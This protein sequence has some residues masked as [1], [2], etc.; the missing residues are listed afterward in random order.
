[1]HALK[2]LEFDAIRERL[3]ER[4]ETAI[5]AARALELTP[6]FDEAKVWGHLT[7]TGEA[8]DAQGR[9]SVPSLGAVRDLRGPIHRAGKGG[10]LGGQ[11]LFQIGDAMTAMRVMKAFLTP[12]AEEYSQLGLLGKSLPEERRV[13]DALMTSLEPDGNVRDEASAAL[14]SLRKR[15]VAAFGR[16]VE[17]IQSY[18]TGRHRELLSDPIYTL[19][20]GRYVIPV[21]AEN[22]GKI[23]GIVHDTSASGQT[24]YLEPEDVLQLG[25]ALREIEAAEREE[26]VRI[27][28]D[29]SGR[30]GSAAGALIP[31][32]ELAGALDLL[33]AKGRLGADCRGTM[34]QRTEG[35]AWIKVEGGRHPLLDPERAIPLDI[36]V[37][38]DSS[39][40][41]T[42]PNT[43]GKTVAIKTVGLFVAMAQSGLMLPARDV[44]LGTF[45]QIWA[46]IGDEQSLQQSLSTFSG[47]IKNIA[48]SLRSLRP[49]AIVLMD[50]I[51]AG[52]DPAEGAALAIAVL[53]EMSRRGAAVL[54]STHYGE[55][56]AFAYNT[57]GFQ[58]AA[59]EFDSRTFQPTYRLLMGAPGASHALRI[60][61]RYGIPRDVIEH[62]REGLGTQAQDLASMMERL[63]QSQRQARIAQGEAD[64]RADALRQSEERA[65]RKL[66]EAEEIRQNAHARANEIIEAALREIRLEARNLFEELK[67]APHD[68][69]V[70]ERVR[71]GLKDLDAVGRDFAR[72]FVP[73]RADERSSEGVRRGAAVAIDGYRQTGTVVE[74]PSEGKVMVQV[75]A[76]RLTVPV[77]SVRVVEAPSMRKPRS[78]IQLQK[79]THAVSEIHLREMRAEEAMRDLERFVDDAVLGG[80]PSIR[81]VHGKGEG[82]LRRLTREYL[83]SHPAVGAFRD[84]E[85][86]EGGA[87]VTIATFK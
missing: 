67:R 31:G 17:R 10:V 59:M 44:R 77:E 85:P 79:A 38:K 13:E 37:G 9:Y 47:H 63:E 49:G 86:F 12:R 27:L 24:I 51:G 3:R 29:L 36:A 66:A 87:G 18:T 16:I 55:L 42:G 83:R 84:G 52:T 30:V 41:I 39:L 48:E 80:L 53:E 28:G 57:H 82:I 75:G 25:N 34:P 70:Q 19:R 65:K 35:A 14:S 23:R 33:L 22:R 46:D 7:A 73:T 50:E 54:A 11:E 15:K 40:L 1:M 61:E 26:V 69:Q 71:R 74:E 21:K 6:A 62:A 45:T 60:A 72:E 68:S 8:Y 78:N 4:C 56:K 20:D 58:N 43:G 5:G 81:I 64:R 32:I 76:I 2:V